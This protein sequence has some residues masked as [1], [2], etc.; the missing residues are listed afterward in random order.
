M[1]YYKSTS[2][3]FLVLGRT[4]IANPLPLFWT[5]SGMEIKTDSSELWFDIESDYDEREEW[6]RIEVDGFCIQRLMVPKGR[7]KVCAYRKLPK[8]T[9][10]IIRFLKEVQPMGDDEQQYLLLHG[11]ECDGN[12]YS[13][14]QKKYK[15]EFVGDSL[16]SGEGLT[17]SQSLL[18][19]GSASYGLEGHYAITIADYFNADFRILSQGGWGVHCSCHNDLIHIMPKYYEKVCGVISGENNN[20]LGAFEDN[21]F[22]VWQPDLIII[23]LG[24]NDGFALNRQAWINPIDGLPHRQITNPYGGVEELSAIRFEQSVVAFLKKVRQLNPNAY[25]LWAYG[26]CDHTMR[27]YIEKAISDYKQE[28]NDMQAEFQILP[29]TNPMWVGSANHPGMKEHQLTAEVLINKI[30]TILK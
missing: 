8:D 3:E 24:S 5:G 23:N 17:G 21:N 4:Q 18:N 22:K 26:M 13:I 16:T 9:I 2:N 11:I 15:I 25:L 14:P 30:K 10:R 12:I 1:K 20:K 27:P 19:A 7:N 29:S 28:T 6:I